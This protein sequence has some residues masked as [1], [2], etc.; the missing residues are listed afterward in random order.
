MQELPD[1]VYKLAPELFIDSEFARTEVGDCLNPVSKG[2]LSPENIFTIGKLVTGERVANTSVTTVYK[3][4]G[5][6][7]YDLFVAQALYEKAEKDNVG[8][9]VEF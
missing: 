4:A 9:L 7:L 2:L 8:I 5:M 1:A 6:A 3:S